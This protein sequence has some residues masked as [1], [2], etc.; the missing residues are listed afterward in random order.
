MNTSRFTACFRH[1]V[2]RKKIKKNLWDQGT[3][4]PTCKAIISLGKPCIIRIISLWTNHNTFSISELI[5]QAWF[6]PVMYIMEVTML[7][8]TRPGE[9]F[10]P[11]PTP[12][13]LHPSGNYFLVQDHTF[14]CKLWLSRPPYLF[15]FHA[16]LLGVGMDILWNHS[17]FWKSSSTSM[18][19]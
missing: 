18:S 19:G 17:L 3:Y 11:L 2:K 5:I 8:L 16:T 4:V 10:T 12:P 14:L 9:F 1:L 7:V 15:K 6:R 13:Q